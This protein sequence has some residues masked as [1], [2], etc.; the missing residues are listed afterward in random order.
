LLALIQGL[1]VTKAI[2]SSISRTGFPTALIY[3][4][5]Y[6]ATNFTVVHQ[7]GISFDPNRHGRIEVNTTSF[8]T[9]EGA[10]DQLVTVAGFKEIASN[11]YARDF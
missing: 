9:D 5:L 8:I 4:P 7:H 10:H 2:I 11:L 3:K 6:C 1:N